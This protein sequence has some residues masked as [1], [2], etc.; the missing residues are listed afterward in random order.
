MKM[1]SVLGK[2]YTLDP[3]VS[4]RYVPD[5]SHESKNCSYLMLGNTSTAFTNRIIKSDG[6]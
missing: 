6:E 5:L 2:H 3:G 1:I 4:E